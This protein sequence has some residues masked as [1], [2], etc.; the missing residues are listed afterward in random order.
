MDVVRFA[1]IDRD[2]KAGVPVRGYGTPPRDCA[3][4]S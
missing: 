3:T 1:Q 2:N 4:P